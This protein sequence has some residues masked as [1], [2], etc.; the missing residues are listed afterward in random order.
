MHSGGLP[1][2]H[3]GE[4]LH[5]AGFYITKTAMAVLHADVA[6]AAIF[7]NGKAQADGDAATALR[8]NC[9]N[10][11][12]LAEVME[13]GGCAAGKFGR[14]FSHCIYFNRGRLFFYV[15][16][17]NAVCPVLREQGKTDQ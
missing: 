1:F 16:D 8:R 12:L 13:Q 10:L 5:K 7:F 2:G 11:H 9:S 17:S 14:L 15:N 3:G 4:A 6:G